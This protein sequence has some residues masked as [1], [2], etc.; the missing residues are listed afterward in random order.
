[1]RA[2]LLHEQYGAD[3]HSAYSTRMRRNDLSSSSS[4]RE[5]RH[6]ES[7][8]D[9]PVRKQKICQGTRHGSARQYGGDDGKCLHGGTQW[10][11]RCPVLPGTCRHIAN[12]LLV[13]RRAGS[14]RVGGT[15]ERGS[16]NFEIIT[17]GIVHQGL[18][19]L[20]KIE[21]LATGNFRVE[22]RA[23]R[24][25]LQFGHR[26]FAGFKIGDSLTGHTDLIGKFLGGPAGDL[27]DDSQIVL[28]FV[29]PPL[30]DLDSRHAAP[31]FLRHHSTQPLLRMTKSVPFRQ[32]DRTTGSVASL[33]SPFVFFI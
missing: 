29:N 33:A 17:D 9:V 13:S 27:A 15:G 22:H 19:H 4:Q 21:V 16:R 23:K 8:F 20:G 11:L 25:I 28:E 32:P 10:T 1:M 24:K 26:G 31:P 14:G 7:V 3:D 12:R 6:A 18:N 30:F 5:T 2:V